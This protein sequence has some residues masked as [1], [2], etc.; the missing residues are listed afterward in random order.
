VKD[1]RRTTQRQWSAE[2]KIRGSVVGEK[3]EKRSATIRTLILRLS[4]RPRSTAS[5]DDG[6]AVAAPAL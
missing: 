4:P 2:E 1:I 5:P 6:R 3:R